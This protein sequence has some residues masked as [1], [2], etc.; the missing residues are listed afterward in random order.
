[1]VEKQFFINNFLTLKLEE[2]STAIY[3]NGEIFEHC[4]YLAFQINAY[5]SQDYDEISSIDELEQ[6]DRSTQ[7]MKLD[8][9]PEEEFWGHC[10]NLQAWA[11]NNYDT[12]LLHSNL[13]FPLLKKLTEVGDSLAKRVF[14]EEIAQRIASGYVPVI[15][16]LSE[17]GYLDYLNNE[18]LCSITDEWVEFNNK[19]IP[20]L[21]DSLN[22]EQRGITDL[23]EL[24]RIN[25]FPLLKIL[26][27]GENYLQTLPELIKK[28]NPLQVLWLIIIC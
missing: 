17:N 12:R 10:S 21:N 19:M 2:N 28:L 3:V 22:L 16:Y 13:A 27:L 6:Q 4:K 20:I 11:E 26:K 15:E 18:E 8:I 23:S 5:Q 1:M 25:K 24:K 9:N 7:F 14:K